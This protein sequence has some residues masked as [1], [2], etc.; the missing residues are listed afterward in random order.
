MS[1]PVNVFLPLP[2]SGADLDAAFREAPDRWLPEPA[3]PLD[4]GWAIDVHAGPIRVPV[5]CHVGEPRDSAEATWRS[6]HWL[7]AADG[8]RGA[9]TRLL[10]VLEAQLGLGRDT[11][12]A[13]SLVLTGSYDPPAAWF[14]EI[15]DSLGLHRVARTTLAGFLGDIAERMTAAASER[16]ADPSFSDL[17]ASEQS[18]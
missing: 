3:T 17:G 7:P 10:P 15:A 13:V 8:E 2:G 6:I 14:G 1:R 12:G 16:A 18:R 9:H 11:A 4:A 5:A